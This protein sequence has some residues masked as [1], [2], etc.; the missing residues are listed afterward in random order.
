MSDASRERHDAERERPQETVRVHVFENP[1][2][3]RLDYEL[4]ILLDL[5]AQTPRGLFILN[6]LD[7]RGR[8]ENH[9]E[10]HPE[11]QIVLVYQSARRRLKRLHQRVAPGMKGDCRLEVWT[12]V[13]PDELRQLVEIVFLEKT[14]PET[15][16]P[17]VFLGALEHLIERGGL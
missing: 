8:A 7:A 17:E 2:F 16:Q 13:G 11:N 15:L 9:P 10:H 1:Q 4:R 14:R 6:F 5:V 3:E 12:D